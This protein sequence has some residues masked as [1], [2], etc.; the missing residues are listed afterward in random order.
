MNKK[1]FIERAL[2]KVKCDTVLKGGK[3]IDVLGHSIYEGDVGI[4]EDV[5]VG[6]G[7]YQGNEEIDV[8]GMYI[9][10][11]LIDSHIHI[12]STMLSPTAFAELVLSKGVTSVFADPHEIANVKGEE[13]LDF[14]LQNGKNTPLDIY[15]MLPSCVPATPFEHNGAVIDAEKTKQLYEKG[16]FYGL[17][18]MMNYPG[19]LN[20]DEDVLKKLDICPYIDGHAP[21]LSGKRLN[22]YAGCGITNDHECST[23]AEVYEKIK[24]GL[25]IFIREGTGAKNLDV[26]MECVTP[27]NLPH[28]AF[29]TDDKQTGAIIKEGTIGHCINKAIDKGLDIISAYTIGSINAAKIYGLK[30]TGAIAP[31]YKADIIVNKTKYVKDPEYVFKN[32]KIVARKGEAL[33]KTNL[34]SIESVSN[35]VNI[36]DFTTSDLSLEFT[37]DTPV[38]EIKENSLIS[39][40]TK[41]KDRSEVSLCINMERHNATGN[42]GKCYVSGFTV[43]N[44]AIAQ[45]I[46]HDS[47]NITAL[48]SDEKNIELAI[49]S[50]GKEGGIALVEDC[51][52]K[53]FLKL[54]IAGLMSTAE[55]KE[56]AKQYQALTEKVEALSPEGSETIM[57]VLTFISLLVIPHYKLSDRG[58]FD[59][60]RFQFYENV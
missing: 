19:L 34:V 52:L 43:K 36:K 54:D 7:D 44:G 46:G 13:G 31:G 14:M 37:K 23:V 53:A 9:A 41:G 42:I 51:K 4:Y 2:G 32:G 40:L 26:I 10:P 49:K 8:S 1:D 11:G 22:A 60:D 21:L 57:M 29:C 39:H 27:Y 25:N 47:H 48:G 28:F 3:I 20:C 5:I 35:T 59:V 6:V 18:E 12:E 24:T 58:I 45:T 17:A 33:F 38:I 16:G 50:L 55:P 15:Y 56:L 30:K